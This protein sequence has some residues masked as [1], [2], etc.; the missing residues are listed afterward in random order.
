VEN[1]NRCGTYEKE[2]K[3]GGP[4]WS[5]VVNQSFGKGSGWQEVLK[6]RVILRSELIRDRDIAFRRLVWFRGCRRLRVAGCTR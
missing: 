3:E 5:G 4:I 2:A 6:W 1:I